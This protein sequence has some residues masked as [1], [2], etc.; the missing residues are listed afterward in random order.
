MPPGGRGLHFLGQAFESSLSLKEGNGVT[1]IRYGGFRKRG[2][3]AVGTHSNELEV[4]EIGSRWGLTGDPGGSRKNFS[5][6]REHRKKTNLEKQDCPLIAT[7]DEENMGRSRGN[8]NHA[9]CCAQR[10]EQL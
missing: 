6:N 2:F 9:A 7:E 10:D 8:R 3:P 4:P 1:N 5:Q